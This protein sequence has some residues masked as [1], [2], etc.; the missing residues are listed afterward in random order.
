MRH[1]AAL[2]VVERQLAVPRLLGGLRDLVGELRKIFL[3]DVAN[4]RH[5][6]AA[7]GVDGHADVHV[8]LVDDLVGLQ[9]DRRVRLR[10]FLQRGRRGL[11]SETP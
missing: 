5:E 2:H 4:H 9:I 6:Q 7:I 3:V 11:S 8:L 10:E 1:R